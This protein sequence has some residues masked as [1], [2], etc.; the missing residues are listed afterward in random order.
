MLIIGWWH[1]IRLFHVIFWTLSRQMSM[2]EKTTLTLSSKIS[3]PRYPITT[4]HSVCLWSFIAVASVSNH[5]IP[6]C[7]SNDTVRRPIHAPHWQGDKH[8]PLSLFWPTFLGVSYCTAICCYQRRAQISLCKPPGCCREVWWIWC[9][10]C[11]FDGMFV[12]AAGN[13]GIVYG[14]HFYVS[15]MAHTS[16][17]PC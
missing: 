5:Q 10:P 4:V 15:M 9:L 14:A 11:G 16:V 6:A 13:L 1:L 7:A 17:S 8:L 12:A 3:S 2:P